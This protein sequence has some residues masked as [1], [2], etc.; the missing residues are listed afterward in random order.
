MP[1]N[2][3]KRLDLSVKNGRKEGKLGIGNGLEIS[4]LEWLSD[5]HLENDGKRF[6]GKMLV[7]YESGKIVNINRDESLK[8]PKRKNN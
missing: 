7:K 5:L 1:K 8:K 3:E 4:D 2:L 6:Y